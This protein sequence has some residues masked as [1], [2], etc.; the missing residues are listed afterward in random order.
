M[1]DGYELDP[2]DLRKVEQGINAAMKE[3]KEFG[4]DITANLGHGYSDMELKGLEVGH[5]G[6]RSTFAD[7]CDRWGWGVHALMRDANDIAHRLNLSA[8]LYHEQERYASD[9]LK[10]V[11]SDVQGDLSLTEDEVTARSWSETLKD[12]P[13]SHVANADYSQESVMRGAGEGLGA[14]EQTGQ[15]IKSSPLPPLAAAG[16]GENVDWQWDGA[17]GPDAGRGDEGGDD[18]HG[19]KG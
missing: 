12:N 19:G 13:L 14:W 18:Q 1:A 9:T 11:V 15:D 8:G 10:T 7:F 4:F 3:L 6:L 5:E 2:E 17:P 16:G